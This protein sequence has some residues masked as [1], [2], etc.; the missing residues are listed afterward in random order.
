MAEV[1][2]QFQLSVSTLREDGGAERFHYFLDCDGLT[3]EL[4]FGRAINPISVSS[5]TGAC[6]I[7]YQ[8]RPK[9]PMPTGCKSVYLSSCQQLQDC[10][11]NNLGIPAC[12]LEGGPEDLSTH[13]LRHVDCWA[14]PSNASREET[15]CRRI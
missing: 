7:L 5:S 4:V 14:E 11:P 12:D 13:E 8:T 1:L 6:M 9:A 10:I 2:E 3:R 15:N